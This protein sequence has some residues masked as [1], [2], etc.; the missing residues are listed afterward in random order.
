MRPMKQGDSSW[1][2]TEQLCSLAGTVQ[3]LSAPQD[4]H[5]FTAVLQRTVVSAGLNPAVL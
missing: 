2:K 4:Q 3:V 5:T 1:W